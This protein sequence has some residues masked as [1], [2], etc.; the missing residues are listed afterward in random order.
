VFTKDHRLVIH[1]SQL[2]V[3]SDPFMFLGSRTLLDGETTANVVKALTEQLPASNFIRQKA[4]PSCHYRAGLKA[5][6]AL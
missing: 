6:F 3:Y 4:K 2:G 5:S 1:I